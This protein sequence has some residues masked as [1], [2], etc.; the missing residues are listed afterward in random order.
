MPLKKLNDPT[1]LLGWKVS[2]REM[3]N[4]EFNTLV[5]Q[6][7]DKHLINEEKGITLNCFRDS[8]VG[9]NYLGNEPKFPC[10]YSKEYSNNA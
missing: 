8:I 5:H 2:I 4:E 6:S 3:G 10:C 1:E 7:I 9:R